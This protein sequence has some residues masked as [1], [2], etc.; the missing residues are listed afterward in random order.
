MPTLSLA[1]VAIAEGSSSVL[2]GLE[3]SQ[4]PHTVL[5]KSVAEPLPVR[6]GRAAP[7]LEAHSTA[8]L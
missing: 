5:C 6:S 4:C 8:T 2:C 3:T 7:I 1:R